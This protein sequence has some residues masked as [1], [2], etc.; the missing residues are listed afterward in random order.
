MKESNGF[1][2]DENLHVDEEVDAIIRSVL[3]EAASKESGTFIANPTNVKALLRTYQIMK[4][5]TK[6]TGAKVSYELNEPFLSMGSVSVTGKALEFSDSEQFM[7]AVRLVANF[8]VYPKTDGT[9]AMDFTFNGLTIR[10]DKK[11]EK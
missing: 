3:K 2:F 1:E 6:G 9:V 4:R 11:E 7:E 8:N 5:L 10:V